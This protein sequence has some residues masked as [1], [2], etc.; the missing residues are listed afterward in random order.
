MA[1]GG[2]IVHGRLYV[3]GADV[4]VVDFQNLI[5]PCPGGVKNIKIPFAVHQLTVVAVAADIDDLLACHIGYAVCVGMTSEHTHHICVFGEKLAD[6]GGEIVIVFR[7]G[8]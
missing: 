2:G 3:V 8:V 6:I 7:S 5:A 4:V 1:V